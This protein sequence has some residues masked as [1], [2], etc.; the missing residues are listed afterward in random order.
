MWY[1]DRSDAQTETLGS[2]GVQ[3]GVNIVWLA[4]PV[5]SGLEKRDARF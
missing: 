4:K 2:R 3:M 1:R 5:F